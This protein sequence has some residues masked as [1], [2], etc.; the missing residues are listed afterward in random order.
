MTN[1]RPRGET[2]P[3]LYRIGC[4]GRLSSFAETDDGRLLVTLTG[5]R[6]YAGVPLP[7]VLLVP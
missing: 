4:L 2:G 3:G 7:G 5:V 1:R 6:S